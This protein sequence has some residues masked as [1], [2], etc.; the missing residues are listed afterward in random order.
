MKAFLFL[1]VAVCLLSSCKAFTLP[2]DATVNAKACYDTGN[3][4]I[5]AETDGKNVTL[6]GNFGKQ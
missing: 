3:G 6:S 4:T 1:A 5:C 2:N